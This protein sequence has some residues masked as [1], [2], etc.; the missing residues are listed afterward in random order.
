MDEVVPNDS[1]E[2]ISE[3]PQTGNRFALAAETLDRYMSASVET[4]H[5]LL[6]A[7]RCEMIINPRSETLALRTPN[8]GS[9]PDIGAYGRL[10]FETVGEESEPHSWTELTIDASG[11]AYESYSLLISIVDL[12]EAGEPLKQA[13]N[14]SLAAYN[15]LL[16]KRR[17]LSEDQQTG[18]FGELG[19]LAHLV[20][21]LGEDPA[22]LAWLGPASEE[23]DFAL[24]NFDVEVKTTR[25]EARRHT[26]GSL[27]Q[28][29][30]SPNRR[31]YFVSIQV[32]AAGAASQG[33]SLPDR[34]RRIRAMLDNSIELYDQRLASLGWDPQTADELYTQRYIARSEPRVYLV[35]KTFPAITNQE[36]SAI[37]SRPESIVGVEYRIDVTT[38]DSTTSPAL[39]SEFSERM[40]Q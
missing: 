25:A 11:M 32:T 16:A 29:T 34:V 40:Q 3:E 15:A 33:E 27:G 39:L 7:P 22:I 5:V 19:L 12:L 28:L 9:V 1:A 35:D 23:H 20:S 37:L 10:K 38:L 8:R 21:E 26:I 31:L 36:I 2:Q 13:V 6:D 17:K 4:R 18:L 30:P 14:T 24:P